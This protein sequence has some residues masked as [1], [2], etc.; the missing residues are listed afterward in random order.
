MTL[1]IMLPISE[2]SILVPKKYI[3]TKASIKDNINAIIPIINL[4]LILIFFMNYQIL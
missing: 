4:N 1:V 2:V 3:Q